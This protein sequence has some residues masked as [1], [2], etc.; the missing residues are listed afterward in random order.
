MLG[1][2]GTDFAATACVYGVELRREDCRRDGG[3]LGGFGFVGEEVRGE[4]VLELAGVGIAGE[5]GKVEVAEKHLSLYSLWS[6]A[7]F[8][9][10]GDVSC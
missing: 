2:Y 3:Y 6:K 7:T 10:T 5:V 8:C 9:E 1:G 4:G